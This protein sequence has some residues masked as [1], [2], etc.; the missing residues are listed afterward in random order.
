MA[1]RR[2]VM[3]AKKP[4]AVVSPESA[5]GEATSATAATSR[6]GSRSPR[7]ATSTCMT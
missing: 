6:A 3:M 7:A 1:S 2:M 4:T 5:M